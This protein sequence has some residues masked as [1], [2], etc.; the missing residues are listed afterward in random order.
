[1]LEGLKTYRLTWV[2]PS[3][4][5]PLLSAYPDVPFDLFHVGFPFARELAA[6]A[7]S[8]PNVWV[9]ICWAPLVSPTAA[10]RILE[11]YIDIIPGNKLLWGGDCIHPVSALGAAVIGR[12]VVAEALARKLEAGAFTEPQALRLAECILHD[13]AAELYYSD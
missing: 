13:N 3:L 2:R 9:D 11:E 7:L 12:R 10:V 1:M 5:V 8:W 6:V 4:L